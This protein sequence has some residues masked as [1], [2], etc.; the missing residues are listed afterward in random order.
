MKKTYI[1]PAVASCN[2]NTEAMI[3][4]SEQNGTEITGSN[5]GDF[6]LYSREEE[7]SAWDSEW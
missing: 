2:M 5:K 7:G 3:A 4:L 1:K 6:D